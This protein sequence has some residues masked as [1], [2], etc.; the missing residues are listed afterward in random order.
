MCPLVISSTWRSQLLYRWIAIG[1]RWVAIGHRW[2]AI[3]HRWVAM[4]ITLV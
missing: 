4:G 2:I 1:H 3:G